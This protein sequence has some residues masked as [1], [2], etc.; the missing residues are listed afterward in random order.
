MYTDCNRDE[1]NN[2]D[3]PDNDISYEP[4]MKYASVLVAQASITVDDLTF[5]HVIRRSLLCW[6]SPAHRVRRRALAKLSRLGDR[7]TGQKQPLYESPKFDVFD[8][9]DVVTSFAADG[10]KRRNL[11]QR[12]RLA[13]TP[14]D[15]CGLAVGNVATRIERIGGFVGMSESEPICL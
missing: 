10:R 14:G 1:P 3:R 12:I 2:T 6:V 4:A 15:R 7:C 9:T 8:V 5:R 13:D 11:P